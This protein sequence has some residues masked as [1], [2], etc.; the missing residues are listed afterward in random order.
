MAHGLYYHSAIQHDT[1]IDFRVNMGMSSSRY[2]RFKKNY[3][4]VW[5]IYNDVAKK[6]GIKLPRHWVAVDKLKKADR[7][8][9]FKDDYYILEPLGPVVHVDMNF[10][11]NN[12]LSTSAS[13]GSVAYAFNWYQLAEQFFMVNGTAKQAL[14][15]EYRVRPGFLCERW[16]AKSMRQV[17]NLTRRT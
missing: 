5:D 13:R 10:S 16:R 17:Y 9:R 4:F 11:M 6:H 12:N 1:I 15:K 14:S 3:E 2:A 8:R 7:Y